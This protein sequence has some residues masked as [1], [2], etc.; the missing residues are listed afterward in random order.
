MV[1]RFDWLEHELPV[2]PWPEALRAGL[3]EA[4]KQV[5]WQAVREGE[6]DPLESLY[7]DFATIFPRMLVDS[8]DVLLF[9]VDGRRG[10]V[11]DALEVDV[12]GELL[13]HLARPAEPDPAHLAQRR[14]QGDR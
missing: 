1:L 3:C 6:F 11:V 13:G 2:E 9:E 7:R 4:M 12:P 8:V 5:G 14:T 10:D